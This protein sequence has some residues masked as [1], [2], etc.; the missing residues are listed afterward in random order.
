VAVVNGPD[1]VVI[2]G[3]RESV[4]AVGERLDEAGIITRSLRVSHAFHS[5]LMEPILAEFREI[6]GQISYAAPQIPLIS[7]VTAVSLPQAPRLGSHPTPIIG[8][9]TYANRCAILP[10]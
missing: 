10:V 5:P 8:P 3:L 9:T 6:A 7:N 4:A 1:N 2:S